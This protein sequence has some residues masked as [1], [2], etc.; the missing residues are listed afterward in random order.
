MERE[1][2]ISRVRKLLA[3]SKS[4][5]EAEATLAASRAMKLVLE[6]KLQE[7]EVIK[8]EDKPNIRHTDTTGGD[9]DNRKWMTTLA[10]G[11]GHVSFCKVITHTWIGKLSFVGKDEDVA[12]ALHLYEW[13][14][15]Q[16]A[17]I[18][19][20]AAKEAGIKGK[21]QFKDFQWGMAVRVSRRLIEDFKTGVAA[22]GLKGNEIVA[23][24]GKQNQEYA[25]NTWGALVR[26]RGPQKQFNDAARKGWEAGERVNLQKK[27][28]LT[29]GNKSLGSGMKALVG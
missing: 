23:V 28:E 25:E 27:T 17:F 1:T 16:I 24:T 26:Q 9:D 21:K 18:S 10:A 15:M 22:M 14:T 20:S 12:V 4:S 13:L 3:L 29:A 19:P 2:V 6:H 11:I 7:W 8:Q 5:N